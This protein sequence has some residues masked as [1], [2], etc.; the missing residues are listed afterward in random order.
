MDTTCSTEACRVVRGPRDTSW[1]SY[2]S[3]VQTRLSRSSLVSHR[4]N[5]DEH[6]AQDALLIPVAHCPME[7]FLE[8]FAVTFPVEL[9]KIAKLRFLSSIDD[10]GK[11]GLQRK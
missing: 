7:T 11:T 9:R 2:N 4:Y 10:S 3:A 1:A 6:T 5:H 8:R